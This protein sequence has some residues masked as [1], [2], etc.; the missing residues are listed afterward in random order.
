M[1]DPLIEFDVVL[2]NESDGFAGFSCAGRSSDAMNV[3]LGIRR[4]VVIDD[5]INVRYVQTTRGNV[6]SDLKKNHSM[7][8]V[9]I[10]KK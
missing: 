1:F 9:I 3:R 2:C 8:K 6:S 7:F 5:D 10:E 4:Y